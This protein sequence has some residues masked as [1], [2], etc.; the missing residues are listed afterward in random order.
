MPCRRPTKSRASLGK[1]G[2]QPP[3]R[4]VWSES[5]VGKSGFPLREKV[6][7]PPE[8]FGG[9]AVLFWSWEVRLLVRARAGHRWGKEL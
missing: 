1:G 4:K 8:G 6:W 2:T 3:G 5:L 7:F 9:P